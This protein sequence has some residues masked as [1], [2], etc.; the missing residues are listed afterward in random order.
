[1]DRH[2]DGTGAVMMRM[3]LEKG[4]HSLVTCFDRF[5]HAKSEESSSALPVLKPEERREE[6]RRPHRYTV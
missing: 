1:M 5:L 2:P 6:P 3:R 4:I